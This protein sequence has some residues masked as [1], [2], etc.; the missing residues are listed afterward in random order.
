M[1][2]SIITPIK[3]DFDGLHK[4]FNSINSLIDNESIE[5]IVIDGSQDN[6]EIKKITKLVSD[7]NSKYFYEDKKGI[8]PA[9]NKGIS[10][11]LGS[12]CWFLNA[13]DLNLLDKAKLLK[14][15]KNNDF[16]LIK[17]RPRM[18]GRLYLKKEKLSFKYLIFQTFNHQSYFVKRKVL[19]NHKFAEYL[20]LCSDYKQLLEIWSKK[21]K[22][23]YLN[24]EIVDYD[25]SGVTHSES[26]KNKIRVERMISTL[27]IS[28]N[29]KNV[30][31]FLMLAIQIFFYAPK[32][33]FS[34]LW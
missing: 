20:Y 23:T 7:A 17:C 22:C 33:L 14:I 2:L 15:L 29:S 32:I 25:L 19:E 30:M 3:D 9:M 34:K 5:W 18:S 26:I 13:K 12:F 4:T 1:L 21:Y 28:I 6:Q 8:Y 24:D 11:S 27:R 31:I 16:D 10:E